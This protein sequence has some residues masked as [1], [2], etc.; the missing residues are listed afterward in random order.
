MPRK[1]KP[2]PD[3][4]F[5]VPY[6]ILGPRGAVLAEVSPAEWWDALAETPGA[7]RAVDASG[8]VLAVSWAGGVAARARAQ[9]E[10]DRRA[11]EVE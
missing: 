9:R 1:T 5:V 8:L 7:V 4:S 10:N 6:R 3:V 11:D 2:C